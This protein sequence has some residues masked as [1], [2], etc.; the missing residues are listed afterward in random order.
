MRPLYKKDG[1][2]EK[3][4][5]RP[6]S[7]LS[8]ISKVYE[9]CLYDQIYD[10]F[11]NG[12][13][14]YQCGFRKG[15]NIQNALLSMVE[16]VLLAGDKK[17]FFGAILTDLSKAFDCISYDVLIDKLNAYGFNL[18]ALNFIHNYLFERS[19]KTKVGFSLSDL[20]DILYG[21]P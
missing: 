1:R 20:L 3:S 7:V 19:Q 4:N 17:E 14:R 16:K 9:R 5:Y 6:V 21:V 12:F 11:E 8:N 13:S 18:N 2:K 10:F 15:S